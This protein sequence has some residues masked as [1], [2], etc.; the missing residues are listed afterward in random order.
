MPEEQFS[1]FDTDTTAI[2][3]KRS[4]VRRKAMIFSAEKGQEIV[5][6]LNADTAAC[7]SEDKRV[8]E[9]EKYAA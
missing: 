3:V 5:E 4:N 8:T 7:P 6:K 1:I 2:Q 9:K